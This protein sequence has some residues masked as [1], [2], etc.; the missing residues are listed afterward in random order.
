MTASPRL[1]NVVFCE[2]C[3]QRQAA[4][5]GWGMLQK[6]MIIDLC[7]CIY[8][9]KEECLAVI[10]SSITLKYFFH[11]LVVV[12]MRWHGLRLLFLVINIKQNKRSSMCVCLLSCFKNDAHSLP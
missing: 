9:S 4:I 5:H 3:V 8:F 2:E 6:C 11:K 1:E 12:L 10:F 7:V